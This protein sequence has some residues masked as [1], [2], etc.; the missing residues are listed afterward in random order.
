VTSEQTKGSSEAS[1]VAV[2]EM[3]ARALADN[4]GLVSVEEIQRRST[5]VL[6][7]TTAQEDI[8]KIIG[9]QGRTVSALR[10]L[11][12]LAAEHQGTRATLDIKD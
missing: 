1:L 7:L 5:T 8:G 10:T 2:V 3:V 4:P 9:R 12:S 6:Q 11:V